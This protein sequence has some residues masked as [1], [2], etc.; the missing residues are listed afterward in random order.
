MYITLDEEKGVY[1]YEAYGILDFLGDLGG[2]LEIIVFFLGIF[3]SPIARHSY[4]I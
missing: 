1:N 2:V 4:K 3:F